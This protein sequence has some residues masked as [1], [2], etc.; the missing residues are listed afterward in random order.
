MI[1]SYV[2]VCVCPVTPNR[3]SA[4]LSVTV[5]QDTNSCRCMGNNISEI[6]IFLFQSQQGAEFTGDPKNK[7]IT[8]VKTASI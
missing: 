3:F 8:L 6:L 5:I 4:I 2:S 1:T 7:L